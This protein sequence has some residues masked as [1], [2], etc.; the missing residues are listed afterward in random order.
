MEQTFIDLERA[1]EHGIG[2]AQ[3]KGWNALVDKL[4]DANASLRYYINKEQR[5]IRE[6]KEQATRARLEAVQE[7]PRIVYGAR[8]SWWESIKH[9]GINQENGLPV[10]P[11]CGSPLLEVEN[12][13]RWIKGAQNFEDEGMA[14][15]VE[16]IEWVRGK[17]FPGP[18]GINDAREQFT[19]ATGLMVG[20][21]KGED[22]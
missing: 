18:T 9:V 4:L 12:E 2:L 5:F 3:A 17:C 7:D 13:E 15:Y 14:N 20:E 1:I 6:A 19:Y 10:C 8:C 22:Q 16:F 21:S 11:H